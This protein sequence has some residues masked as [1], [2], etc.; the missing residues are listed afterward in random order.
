MCDE[1]K[2]QLRERR[3][4]EVPLRVLAQTTRHGGKKAGLR[5]VELQITKFNLMSLHCSRRSND[6]TSGDSIGLKHP[7]LHQADY[8]FRPA[9]HVPHLWAHDQVHLR[10]HALT[11]SHPAHQPTVRLPSITA[12]AEH[13]RTNKRAQSLHN[14]THANYTTLAPLRAISNHLPITIILLLN[15]APLSSHTTRQAH[16]SIDISTTL[17]SRISTH[18]NIFNPKFNP[19]GTPLLHHTHRPWQAPPHGHL[20]A[21]ATCAEAASRIPV[22]GKN[23]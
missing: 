20:L 23:A 13:H 6:P 10:Q 4:I 5:N 7:S 16:T 18:H 9:H 11:H 3:Q 22:A 2:D 17:T 21:I 15:P 14:S 19:Y 8:R 1:G 12:T